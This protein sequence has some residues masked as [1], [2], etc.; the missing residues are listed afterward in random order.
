MGSVAVNG[1][2]GSIGSGETK[3]GPEARQIQ[4]NTVSR[5]IDS[6]NDDETMSGCLSTG[7]R[8]PAI[9]RVAFHRNCT[10]WRMALKMGGK[11]GGRL[12]GKLGGKMGRE[13]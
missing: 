3:K 13:K 11:L 9:P 8:H 12:G 4:Q 1:R 7:P 5:G 2:L 6:D 10:R